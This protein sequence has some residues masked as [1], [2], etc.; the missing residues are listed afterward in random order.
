ME[1][2]YKYK[3]PANK[4]CLS[5]YGKVWLYVEQNN[6]LILLLNKKC[7]YYIFDILLLCLLLCMYILYMYSAYGINQ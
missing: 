2:I 6:I 4:D 1:K 3:K 5:L 7:I